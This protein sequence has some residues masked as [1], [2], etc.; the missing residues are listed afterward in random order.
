M[1]DSISSR[2]SLFQ[3]EPESLYAFGYVFANLEHEC[4]I[5]LGKWMVM[6]PLEQGLCLC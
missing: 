4:I 2:E 3:E 1:R 6:R 5:C